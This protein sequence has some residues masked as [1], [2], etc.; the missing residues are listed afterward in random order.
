MGRRWCLLP[1]AAL[2]LAGCSSSPEEEATTPA[3]V[4][5]PDEQAD[6][7]EAA[8]SVQDQLDAAE[9][10][11]DTFGSDDCVVIATA[12]NVI[13]QRAMT[14]LVTPQA[15]DLASFRADIDLAREAIPDELRSDFD[16]YAEQWLTVAEGIG[17][18]G[19]FDP[20]DPEDAQQLGELAEGL[21]SAEIE[22]LSTRLMEALVDRC[23][24]LGQG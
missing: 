18:L 22:E 4:E 15:F 6:E 14:G 20:M 10:A 23:P 7:P 21:D 5:Q 19:D 12:F 13:P 3:A 24:I 1:L 16:L 8:P 11:D 9:E 17:S 2:L